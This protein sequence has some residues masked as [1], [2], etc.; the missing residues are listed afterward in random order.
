MAFASNW[1]NTK[2]HLFR[3]L[4][5][6]NIAQYGE[7]YVSDCIDLKEISDKDVAVF[8]LIRILNP[9]APL[10]YK[11]KIFNDLSAVG[12]EMYNN[13]PN[14]EQDIYEL[15]INGCFVEYLKSNAFDSN[16]IEYFTNCIDKMVLGNENYYYAIMYLLCEQAGY[17]YKDL[18]FNQ[19]ED[20]IEYL[21]TISAEEVEFATSE[22]LSDSKFVM[23]IYSQGYYKQVEEWLDIFTEAEW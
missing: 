14:I 2:K 20:L 3:G 8:K 16:L 13:L 21:D 9:G 19:L 23:W 10:C 18:F 11:G 4:V 5:E 17:A 15:L 12:I 6:K 7:D 22:F 1:E